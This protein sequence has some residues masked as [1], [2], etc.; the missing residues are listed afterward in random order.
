MEIRL[1]TA[2][3]FHADGQTHRRTDRHTDR[4]ADI[5]QLILGFRN[6][7]NAPKIT[8]K[9]D[10]WDIPVYDGITQHVCEWRP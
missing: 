9:K 8:E 7:A 3:F 10:S 5:T 4:Q 2:E 1:V 6:I